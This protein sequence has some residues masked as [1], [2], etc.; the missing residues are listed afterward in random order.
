MFSQKPNWNDHITVMQILFLQSPSQ[1]A[2]IQ[3]QTNDLVI[4]RFVKAIQGDFA[5][6]LFGSWFRV[7]KSHT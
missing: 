1:L 4:D 6:V 3:S 7:A 2:S 5:I